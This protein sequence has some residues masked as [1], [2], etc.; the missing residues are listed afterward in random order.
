M[1]KG[2]LPATGI[3]YITTET[4]L[5][6]SMATR[7]EP[8]VNQTNRTRYTTMVRFH[9]RVFP[10]HLCTVRQIGIFVKQKAGASEIPRFTVTGPAGLCISR[11]SYSAY[12][13]CFYM[14]YRD[15]L[16]MSYSHTLYF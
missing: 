12:I 9:K 8:L 10:I 13:S 11:S 14:H 16:A 2:L 6:G 3:H 1:K 5:V 4:G 7:D 15:G